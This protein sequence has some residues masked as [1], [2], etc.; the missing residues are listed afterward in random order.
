MRFP[1][2]VGD[3]WIRVALSKSLTLTQ[4][5]SKSPIQ[6]P[7]KEGSESHKYLN[8][9]KKVCTKVPTQVPTKVLTKVQKGIKVPTQSC[10]GPLL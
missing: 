8:V 4:K 3:R 7:T 2:H 9:P 10:I 6:I 5:Y 1:A